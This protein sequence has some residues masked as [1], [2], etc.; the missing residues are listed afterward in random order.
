MKPPPKRKR[1]PNG[2]KV[3]C[4]HDE[5]VDIS[6]LKPH[7]K[8]PNKHPIKQIDL[9]AKIIKHQ[10]W[11]S[12][13]VVSSRSNLIVAG[14]ARLEAAKQL[15]LAVVPVNFQEFLSNEDE[16]SHLIADNRIAELAEAD[17]DL[18]AMLIREIGNVDPSLLGFTDLEVREILFQST[19]DPRKKLS[20]RFGLSPFTV[21]DSRTSWWKE[22]KE[23]WDAYGFESELGRDD[24]LQK[25]SEFLKSRTQN[26]GSSVFDPVLCELAYRWM[27]PKG[28]TVF[29][30]FAG[31]SVRGIVA[32]LLGLNY[33]G[34]DLRK[35][36]C[37]ENR[38]QAE[39]IIK[40]TPVPIWHCGSSEDAVDIVGDFRADFVWS[41][42][43]YVDRER[44]SD[45]PR[46]T[47][48]Q[49][50]WG[51]FQAI[52]RRIIKCAVDILREDRFC[53][54][55]IGEA[56]K[57]TKMGEYWGLLP[58]T[59]LAFEEAGA[60][61]YNDAIYITSLATWSMTITKIFS[62]S[63]KLGKIHQNVLFFVK[64]DA[65]K[66]TKEIGAVEFGDTPGQLGL[67]CD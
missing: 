3:H 49:K 10:G 36:Q 33:V 67:K 1:P 5:M 62:G 12:P 27:C 53:G 54:F 23:S 57:P 63:R 30:P 26:K 48:N 47:S 22:R 4:A 43:G 16:I 35:G 45:D 44:Y 14:H 28:G 58:E 17:N 41:C 46:D 65:K 50:S 56:R 55:M 25:F 39:R 38:K 61:F 51:E 66:A 24:N 6:A 42:P 15:K 29:D 40:D 19:Y 37:D 9:L 64:G 18:L 59:I 60:R 20:E 32:S 34:I 2:I 21:F 11:R 13:I 52:Y 7:P 8:N 31:G